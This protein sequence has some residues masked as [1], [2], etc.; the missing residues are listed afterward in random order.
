[1]KL[2]FIGPDVLS[3]FDKKEIKENILDALNHDNEIHLL[4]YGFIEVEVFELILKADLESEINY[5]PHFH[6][7][8]I[9]PFE[10][11]PQNLKEPLRYMMENGAHY[12][13]FGHT[14]P[15]IRRQLY[16][17]VWENILE[18][19]DK[20]VSFYNRDDKQNTKKL[21]IPV[22]VAAKMNKT[23]AVYPLPGEDEEKFKN[24]PLI[25]FYGK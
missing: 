23:G 12:T 13:S 9:Q 18:N 6:F 16:V 24:N 3:E 21:L 20:L 4:I 22:D 25:Q 5:S 7:Y 17:Q 10:D 19:C 11:L 14:T 2:A 8:S 15:V 1:M